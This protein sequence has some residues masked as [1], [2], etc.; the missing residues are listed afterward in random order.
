[1]AYALFAIGV[2]AGY[3]DYLGFSNVKEAGLL[4]R[5]EMFGGSQGVTPFYKW[6]FALFLV[7]LI[8]YVE[9]LRPVAT[10]FLILIIIGILLAHNDSVAQ[11]AKAA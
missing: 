9:P 10:A 3:L 7:G 6:F 8:G 1:M 5:A 4:L 2:M 11:I